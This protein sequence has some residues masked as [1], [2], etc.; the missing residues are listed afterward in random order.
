[1][2]RRVATGVMTPERMNELIGRVSMSTD[3]SS[4]HPSDFVLEAISEEEALKRSVIHDV[5]TFVRP[6]VVVASHTACVSVTRLAQSVIH[7]RDRVSDTFPYL[8][9]P[10]LS[11]NEYRYLQKSRLKKANLRVWLMVASDV[12]IPGITSTICIT[13]TGCMKCIPITCETTSTTM[14]LSK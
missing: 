1:M 8:I 5:V 12:S 6:R 13:W 7:S 2:S 9:H 14:K 10:L 11:S 3:L 4:I